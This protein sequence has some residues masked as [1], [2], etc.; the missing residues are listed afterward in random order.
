M[1]RILIPVL[2]VNTGLA[3]LAGLVLLLR[4]STPFLRQAGD[5]PL[6]CY[7]GCLVFSIPLGLLVALFGP[8]RPVGLLGLRDPLDESAR[9]RAKVRLK[10]VL[11]TLG[12]ALTVGL[13]L[14]IWGR[15]SHHRIEL[16]GVLM[17]CAGSLLVL[18]APWIALYARWFRI[19]WF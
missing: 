6:E 4:I 16:A 19:N 17:A 10:A 3:I 11:R 13:V 1:R 14:G 8:Q 2:A 12:A 5:V 15:P 7:L 9:R 18:V